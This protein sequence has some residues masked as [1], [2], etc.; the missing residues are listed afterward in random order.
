M[1]KQPIRVLVADDSGLIRTAICDA[2]EA[3]EGISVVGT[4]EDGAQAV[5][6]AKELKPDV[7]TLDVQMPNMSG[8]D[9]LRL[10]LEDRPIP[11]IMVSSLARRTA[12]VTLAALD[13]GAVDYVTKPEGGLGQLEKVF[14]GELP[15]KIRTVA[16]TDVGR[17]LRI[18]QDRQ[19]R[20]DQIREKRKA[21]VN[22]VDE[23]R[24]AERCIAIGISTGGPPALTSVFRE[25]S[26][27][28]PP[29]LIVQHMP[30]TF[31]KQFAWRLNSISE[32]NVKEAETGDVLK[33]NHVLLAPGGKHLEL[34]SV[35]SSVKARVRDGDQVSGHKPSVDV[36]MTCAAK[37]YGD[38]CLGV[39]M[40]GMGRD[41]ADGCKLI[42]EAGGYV[43]GQDQESSDVYGMNKVAFVEGGLHRQF[44][45]LELPSIIAEWTSNSCGADSSR[46]VSPLISGAGAA[47][48]G[49]A[50]TK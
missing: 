29:I 46:G 34:R 9:A 48:P 28:L 36:M 41:G 27:P 3:S 11:V 44:S 22:G 19:Q 6:K 33:P 42:K 50:L 16:G 45:L 21:G 39:I 1:S 10:I 40:T 32:L 2:L 47:S 37:L 8:L 43:V 5:E 7:V 25:L 14:Q 4:A 15:R 35:G 26:T 23:A 17:I 30:A 13:Q 38:K 49:Q 31:T 20:A 24:L 18:R 12:D